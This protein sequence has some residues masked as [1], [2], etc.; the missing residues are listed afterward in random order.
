MVDIAFKRVLI[1]PFVMRMI[2]IFSG[3]KV[4]TLMKSTLEIAVFNLS[5]A[6]LAEAEGADRIELCENPFDGGTTPSYG[7]L[8][9]YPN[10]FRSRFSRSFV[11]GAE[12]FFIQK[13]SS[14][15]CVMIFNS[16]RTSDLKGW[17]RGSCCRMDKL[18]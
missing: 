15:R 18:M 8:N 4:Y 16:A 9:L 13:P 1:M 10:K 5:S 14:N 11:P 7:F 6:L 17:F 2:K 3:R 12:I